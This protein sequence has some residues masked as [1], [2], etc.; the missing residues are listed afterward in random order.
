MRRDDILSAIEQEERILADL[1][2]KDPAKPTFRKAYH[3]G[4]LRSLQEHLRRVTP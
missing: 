3:L 4:V 1:E 2:S